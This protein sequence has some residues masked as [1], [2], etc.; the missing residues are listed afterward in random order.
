M[1]DIYPV[2]K[3]R[4]PKKRK[5]SLSYLIKYCIG[6]IILVLVVYFS[7]GY[8]NEAIDNWLKLKPI[9]IQEE[10]NQSE[11]ST[12][13]Q[14]KIAE[15]LGVESDTEITTTPAETTSQP[16]TTTPANTQ[17]TTPTQEQPAITQP[18][19]IDKL[20]IKIRVLNGNGIWKAAQ[21]ARDLLVKDGFKI[22]STG[23]AENQKYETTV[24]YFHSEKTAEADLV[25]KSLEGKYQVTKEENNTLTKDSDVLVVIGK[26]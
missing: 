2:Q 1:I 21:T 26:K 16:E 6:I 20:T 8:I 14:N 12:D 9:K 17:T 18:A 13:A 15:S 4:P 5:A 19:E 11:K 10:T 25:L 7:L 3:K 22:L 24:V 23:N